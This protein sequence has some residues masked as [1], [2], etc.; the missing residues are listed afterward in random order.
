MSGGLALSREE[1][2]ALVRRYDVPVDP[3]A[4][5]SALDDEHHGRLL[6]EWAR[7]HLTA[8][9]LLTKDE[10]NT[11]AARFFSCPQVPY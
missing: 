6:W 10:L 11:Y 8:D 7:S 4:L 2:L 9:T 5:R 1:L 3:A